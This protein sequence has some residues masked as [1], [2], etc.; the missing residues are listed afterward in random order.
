[1]RVTDSNRE[2]ANQR[3]QKRFKNP[4]KLVRERKQIVHCKDHIGDFWPLDCSICA[5]AVRANNPPTA[6]GKCKCMCHRDTEYTSGKVIC[7]ECNTK[8]YCVDNQRLIDIY[9]QPSPDWEKEKCICWC[10]GNLIKQQG[11][12]HRC[13]H[14][15]NYPITGTKRDIVDIHIEAWW[16]RTLPIFNLDNHTVTPPP[17]MEEWM[18]SVKADVNK[19]LEA[20]RKEAVLEYFRKRSQKRVKKN[21]SLH[22]CITCGKPAEST[23]Y[24]RKHREASNERFRKYRALKVRSLKSKKGEV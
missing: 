16:T 3:R 17:T 22:L 11:L 6:K 18:K 10:H 14:C 12:S 8:P 5:E 9:K 21:K 2:I 23:V 7:T 20:E 15:D 1:M 13:K 24:C 19:L 4:K